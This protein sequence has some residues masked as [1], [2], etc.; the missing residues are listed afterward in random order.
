MQWNN[1]RTGYLSFEEFHKM[2]KELYQQA[3]ETLPEF[4]QLEDIFRFID[5]RK[6]SQLDFQEFTQV[7]R[8]CNP[9]NLLM[10]TT[11]APSDQ[12]I[13]K[14]N[15]DKEATLPTPEKSIPK[16]RH[17]PIYE[18]FVKLIGR[19]RRYIQEEI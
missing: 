17:S 12:V 6:D 8:N 3:S 19:N 1:P 11:P 4:Q 2:M 16:F 13:S 14:P 5:I 10:G 15:Q 7:F 9:P 18:E